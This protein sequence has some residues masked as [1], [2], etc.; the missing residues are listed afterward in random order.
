MPARFTGENTLR[1]SI[2]FGNETTNRAGAGGVTRVNINHGH[3]CNQGFVFDKAIKLIKSPV[4]KSLSIGPSDLLP[5]ADAFQIFKGNGSLC[6]FSLSNNLFT[7]TVVSVPLKTRLFFTNLFKMSFSRFTSLFLQDRFEFCQPF[8]CLIN[9]LTGKYISIAGS[10]DIHNPFIAT[11]KAL[12]VKRNFFWKLYNDIKKKLV[13][14]KSKVCLAFNRL[15]FKTSVL[16]YYKWNFQPTINRIDAC[17]RKSFERKEPLVIDNGRIFLEFMYNFFVYLI[18]LGNLIKGTNHKLRGQFRELCT[19]IFIQKIVKFKSIKDFFI[20]SGCRDKIASIIKYFH[21]LFKG[22]MLLG[23]SKKFCFNSK[24]HI[25][26]V[27]NYCPIVKRNLKKG[28]GQ[29]LCHLKEAVSLPDV[30]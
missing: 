25:C 26:N 19:S 5:R 16:S 7:D 3:T 17:N 11:Q 22:L 8:S 1:L 14:F 2:S 27:A 20:I 23:I 13:V 15:S 4:S 12:R 24:F 9:L 30:L 21:C 28:G 10:K 18:R 29:F 6:A